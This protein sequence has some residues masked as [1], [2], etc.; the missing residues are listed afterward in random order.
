MDGV[1]PGIPHGI[2]PLVE[3]VTLQ[4]EPALYRYLVDRKQER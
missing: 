4:V 3:P 2:V 1:I